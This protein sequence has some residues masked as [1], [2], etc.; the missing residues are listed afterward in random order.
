[1]VKTKLS[2]KERGNTRHKNEILSAALKLFSDK[3]FH[4]V[5]MQE[6]ADESEFAVGTLYKYFESKEALFEELIDDTGQQVLTKF[7]EILEGSGK[8]DEKL[9]KFFRYQPEFQQ[10]HGEV[11]KLYVYELGL[12]GAAITSI[13]KKNSVRD[14]LVS[15]LTQLIKD[16]IQKDLFRTVDPVITA[17][18]IVSSGETLTFETAGTDKANIVNMFRNLEHLFLEGLLI[19]GSLQK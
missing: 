5:S 8:E 11:I 2:R 13:N 12:K 9:S 19:P 14:I 17:K 1:M 6:I 7:V 10:Q 15:K 4:N 16:G 18:A 3:G